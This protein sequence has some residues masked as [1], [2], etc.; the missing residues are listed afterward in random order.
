MRPALQ[1]PTMVLACAFKEGRK[2]GGGGLGSS[3]RLGEEEKE[4]K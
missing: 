1:R 2:G 3:S 4:E